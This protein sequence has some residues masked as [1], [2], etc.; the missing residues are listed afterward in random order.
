MSGQKAVHMIVDR[1]DVA[2]V[3]RSDR[4]AET[5]V[6]EEIRRGKADLPWTKSSSQQLGRL[7]LVAS[8][9]KSATGD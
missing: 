7:R 6:C 2:G 4:R 9:E 8:V 3:Q 1:V 5:I